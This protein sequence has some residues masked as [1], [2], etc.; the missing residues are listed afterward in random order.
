MTLRIAT[1]LSVRE[2]EASLVAAA[3]ESATFRIIVRAFQPSDI[4]RYL[5]DLDV[6]VVGGDTAWLTPAHIRS[7]RGR[8]IG[9]LGVAPNGDRP[10]ADLLASGGVN[11]VVPDSI[12]TEALVHAIR[13]VAPEATAPAT[14]A[15]GRTIAVVGA[16]GAPGC[17]EVALAYAVDV[18]T[19]MS[20]LLIDL[21]LEAPS[22]A[23]RLGLDPRPDLADAIDSV[24]QDGAIE[25]SCT[26][27]VGR[28]AVIT[29]PHRAAAGELRATHL[30]GVVRAATNR[31]Q[32]VVIDLGSSDSSRPML[33]LVD[34]VILVVD[35]SALGIVRA[36]RLV[37]D[38]MGPAP[39]LV[40][41]R[42][43]AAHREHTVAAA[44]RWTGLE[45]SIVLPDRRAV[46]RAACSARAPERRFARSV[47]RLGGTR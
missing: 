44:R 8:G 43:D 11:E 6:V 15:P 31:W 9:V 33:E 12:A 13:F 27:H 21:D 47:A 30:E 7:W 18:A 28:L 5:D 32:S 16:R 37:E 45:P 19:D 24:Q 1:V 2:W 10:A 3:R 34:D 46:R 4:D 25:A 26:H 39:A 29:G 36:A 40:L 38:W 22:I 35:G 23:V 20:C 17:T 42:V 14:E 41:N